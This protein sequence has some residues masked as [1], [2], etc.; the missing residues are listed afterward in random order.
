MTKERLVGPQYLEENEEP[1]MMAYYR[2]WR[3]VEMPSDANA[4]S[5]EENVIRM[6]DI[7]KNIDIVSVFHHVKPGTDQEAFWNTLRDDYVPIL[8]ERGQRIVRTVDYT[9]LL[10]IRE[11]TGKDSDSLTKED[12]RQFAEEYVEKTIT[13]WNLDGLDIDMEQPKITDAE[14]TI[15]ANVMKELSKILKINDDNEK[16]LI[17]DTNMDNH[18]LFKKIAPYI[19]YL[20]IQAYGRELSTLD[21]SW[22]SYKEDIASTKVLFGISFPEENDKNIWHDTVGEYTDSRAYKYAIWQPKDGEKAGMFVYAID[23]DGK[24][25]GDN[26]ISETD[27]AWTRALTESLKEAHDTLEKNNK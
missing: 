4:D 18:K 12:Y 25:Y 26:T 16:L 22:D 13:P 3:D 14:T 15:V 20:F 5:S 8:H 23:R 27:F 10:E 1:I 7:P 24:E 19:S 11:E 21:T 17:Y 2:T 6:T 9:A